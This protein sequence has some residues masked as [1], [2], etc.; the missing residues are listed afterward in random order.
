MTDRP[1]LNPADEAFAV[2]CEQ[3]A[4][5]LALRDALASGRFYSPI[6]AIVAACGEPV[7]PSSPRTYTG[8][9]PEAQRRNV[10]R[11]LYCDGL[12]TPMDRTAR[13]MAAMRGGR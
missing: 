7:R 4:A 10:R 2:F 1:K 11:R 9:M 12:R 8:Y 3:G 6:D 5:A 13:D